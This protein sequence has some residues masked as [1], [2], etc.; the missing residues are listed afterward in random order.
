MQNTR[1]TFLFLMGSLPFISL[2]AF[3]NKKK[4]PTL[5]LTPSCDDHDDPTPSQTEGPYY[6]PDSPARK[7]LAEPG[8]PGTRLIVTGQVLSTNCKPLEKVLLDWWHAD[9]EGN[10]DNAAFKWRGHQYTDKAGNFKLETIV[11]GLYPG[12]TR[13]IH[14]KVQAPGSRVLTTQL[15]FPDEPQNKQDYIFHKALVLQ[16]KPEKTGLNG[17]FTFVLPG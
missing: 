16:V 10:Y 1:R 7:I 4:R 2:W 13:H 11:P 3:Q 6:K 14:V 12:R 5:P 15:Y 17:N 9:L 8:Q